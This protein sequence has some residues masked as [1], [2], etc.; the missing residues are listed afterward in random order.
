[1][2]RLVVAFPG[3]Q[4]WNLPAPPGFQGLRDDL[5]LYCYHQLLP[6]W[7]Q[8]G[9]TYFVTYRL[10]DSLPQ[11][12]L[13][14]L[15]A[16]K[17]EWERRHP[18]ARSSM[19]DDELA[20]ELMRRIEFW[21]DQGMG[22][23][24]L[25]DAASQRVVRTPI[26]DTLGVRCEIGCYVVMPNHVHAVVRPLR[27]Q[28]D[29]LESILRSWKG[30]SARAI[31][32][33]LQRSGR[34]WQSESFDRII[35]DEEH[36]WGTVQYVGNNPKKAGLSGSSTARRIQPGWESAGW[37]FCDSGPGESSQGNQRVG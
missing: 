7:R 6:H 23:C 11:A 1:V 35:R 3:H 24:W 9:A 4:M 22:S 29:P 8:D 25:R 15:R 20:R 2:G 12:K 13:N 14:E 18:G 32:E 5:P 10:N 34:V 16:F 26:H 28:T 36:L 37:T 30:S 17:A 21:L 19:V 31:D 27:P 33:L